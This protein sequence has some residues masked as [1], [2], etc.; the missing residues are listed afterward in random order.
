MLID[1]ATIFVAGGRG[2]DGCV[3]FRREAYVPKGGPNGGDGGNGGSIDFLAAT[4]TDTLLAFAGRHHWRA[5]NGRPGEGKQKHGAHGA[6]RVIR[7]PPGTLII[8]EATGTPV[9]DLKAP[10]ER[11][12][13]ARGGRGG[14]GNEHFKHSTHQVPREATPGEPG[15]EKTLRLELKLVADIGLVGM[16]NAGKSTLL[17]RI[18]AARPRI[19][20]YPF[21]T[22]QPQLGI[23]ELSGERRIVVADIP[24]LIEG[25]HRGQGLGLEFLRHV[26]R[27]RLLLHLVEAQPADGGDPLD[28]YRIIR[29]E[30]CRYPADLAERPT[31]VAVSKVDL[32]PG[33][34]ARQALFDRFAA[35]TGAAPLALSAATGEGVAP[36]LETCWSHLGPAAPARAWS[37]REGS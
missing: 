6:D 28:H 13:V 31:V 36:L 20:D 7:V 29:R 5:E 3:S 37:G 17:A 30:I 24:G 26:E 27:T 15:E 11:V 2:G 33:R 4:E 25:A 18:S 19:A 34:A 21:T 10:G 22:R 9:A 1:S 32:L 8:D 16:P 14:W 23:T 12:R 35:E